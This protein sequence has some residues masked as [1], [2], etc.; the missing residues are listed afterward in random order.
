MTL[1]LL[2]FGGLSLTEA[3]VRRRYDDPLMHD[4]FINACAQMGELERAARFYKQQLSLDPNDAVARER[5]Q[6][7]AVRAQ[8]ELRE[9]S[10]AGLAESDGSPERRGR[11]GLLLAGVLL[12][13][14]FLSRFVP[15][16]VAR[17]HR[18]GRSSL[19]CD[20]AEH[21]QAQPPLLAGLLAG[22]AVVL[23]ALGGRPG[24]MGRRGRLRPSSG[25]SGV[26][27]GF[28]AVL[29]SIGVGLLIKAAALLDGGPEPGRDPMLLGMWLT[30]LGLAAG[31]VGLAALAAAWALWRR[32]LR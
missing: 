31:A 21:L 29:A 16:D 6:Q 7:V 30:L 14:L 25:A 20:V 2:L 10:S 4:G 19:W 18:L 3:D 5:L 27:L 22:A 13:L 11:P 1:E 26:S 32:H 28:A 23:I 17:C 8:F 9:P 15:S 12:G 24:E